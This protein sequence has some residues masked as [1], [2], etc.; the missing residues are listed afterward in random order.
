MESALQP[1][2]SASQSFFVADDV[3]LDFILWPPDPPLMG[4]TS[5]TERRSPSKIDSSDQPNKVEKAP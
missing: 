3:P 2:Q 5:T 1:I 4:D